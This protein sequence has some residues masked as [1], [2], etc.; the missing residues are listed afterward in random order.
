M[1]IAKQEITATTEIT[2]DMFEY[3]EVNSAYINSHDVIT[4]VSQLTGKVVNVGTSIPAGGLFYKSQIV[5]KKDLADSVFDEIPAGYAIFSLPVNSHTTYANSIYPGTRIDLYLSTKDETGK[6]VYDPFITSIEVQRV[7][8]SSGK[9]VFNQNPPG[10]PA[11]LLFSV[12]NDMYQ[13]LYIAVNEISGIDIVPVP[14]NKEYT[15]EA[16]ETAFASETLKA[17]VESRIM[18][19]SEI[20]TPED[21]NGVETNEE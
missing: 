7:R 14:R 3:A 4:S 9:D 2:K 8:D 18:H 1:P 13:I 5:E 20:I 17:M 21:T 15:T 6:E 11:E 19:I 12:P 16:T 10:T